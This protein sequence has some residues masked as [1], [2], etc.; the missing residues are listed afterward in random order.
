[1]RRLICVF[2]VRI[3]Q[4]QIFSWRG[5]LWV[6]HSLAVSWSIHL[7]INLQNN[8]VEI[9][10]PHS[11]EIPKTHVYIY[12]LFQASALGVVIAL[13]RTSFIEPP[14]DK[15]NNMTYAPSEDSVQTG[16][17]R[18]F[19]VRLKKHWVLSYLLSTL[20]RLWSDWADVQANPSL[21]WAHRSFCGFCREAALIYIKQ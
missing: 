6:F 11:H 2:I 16:R 5:S 1:M 15:T 17:I 21:R 3:W 8:K 10:H 7:H 14:H 9:V 18:V 19:S 12:A 13:F 4:K 20:R